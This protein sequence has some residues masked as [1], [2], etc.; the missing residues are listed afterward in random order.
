MYIKFDV[1]SSE[2]KH[3]HT[4]RISTYIYFHSRCNS[5][6]DAGDIC[7]GVS[8][9]RSDDATIP[10]YCHVTNIPTP[11][12]F[13]RRAT[14]LSIRV[15]NYAYSKLCKLKPR[16]SVGN[17]SFKHEY[18]DLKSSPPLSPDEQ[19]NLRRKRSFSHLLT[20]QEAVEER[21]GTESKQS[22]E[23]SESR[24]AETQ[25]T[26]EDNDDDDI[27]SDAVI[28]GRSSG[29][30]I[31][32]NAIDN[33]ELEPSVVGK[34]LGGCDLDNSDADEPEVQMTFSTFWCQRK[35]GNTLNVP[36][37]ASGEER[38]TV[39]D[40]SDMDG[41]TSPCIPVPSL[42]GFERRSRIKKLQ[43]DLTLIQK[44]LQDLDNLEY[45]VSIV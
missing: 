22:S 6:S 21:R 37:Q 7:M 25:L 20:R 1:F 13:R 31:S 39:V 27:D 34:E 4:V 9:E 36:S 18:E 28:E 26:D 15:T 23:K 33:L 5:I 38:V 24:T 42:L 43:S 10:D 17:V 41:Q 30:S 11:K 35:Y 3:W 29:L 32:L 2:W 14:R 40:S 44:D 8:E 45:Q 16:F 19:P 12:P